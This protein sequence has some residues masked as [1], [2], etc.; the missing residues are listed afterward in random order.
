MGNGRYQKSK[1]ARWLERVPEFLN[2]VLSILEPLLV[3][4]VGV[5][6]CYVLYVLFMEP[7]SSENRQVVEDAIQTLG[8]NWTFA[9]VILLPLFY[10][11]VRIFL[12]EVQEAGGVKRVPRVAEKV[13][14]RNPP[15]KVQ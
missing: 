1:N 10:R 14:E 9:V 13:T 6:L 3:I 12:E 4:G 7:S 11:R 8:A 2:A 5:A 15:K